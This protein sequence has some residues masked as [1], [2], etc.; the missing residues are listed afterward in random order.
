L[1]ELPMS[2]GYSRLPFGVC[3]K[4]HRMLAARTLRPL[5]PL[6]IAARLGLITRILLSPETNS[7]TDMLTLSRRLIECGHRH[8]H[9]FFH[10]PSLRPGLSPFAATPADVERIYGA[11]ASYVEH[12]SRMAS[13]AF[14][15]VSEA[16]AALQGAGSADQPVA[17]SAPLSPR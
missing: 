4:V 6:G 17:R 5:H 8:L 13:L 9:L 3:S 12:L 1:V 15:T 7:A 14:V 11:I 16:V 2:I 10:S